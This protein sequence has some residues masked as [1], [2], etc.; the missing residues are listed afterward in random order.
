M[1]APLH[2]RRLH[3]GHNQNQA[4]AQKLVILEENVN[5]M[6]GPKI[7]KYLLPIERYTCGAYACGVVSQLVYEFFC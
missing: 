3:E 5:S 4:M 6:A 2:K 1:S 7:Q